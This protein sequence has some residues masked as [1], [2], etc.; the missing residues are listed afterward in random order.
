VWNDQQRRR[1]FF[2]NYAKSNGFDFQNAQDWYL[3]SLDDLMA[4]KVLTPTLLNKIVIL[5]RAQK[6]L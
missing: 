6:G 2:E 1:E 3:Q 4:V 5:F